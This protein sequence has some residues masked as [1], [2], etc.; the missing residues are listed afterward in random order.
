MLKNPLNNAQPTGYFYG[1]YPGRKIF[2]DNNQLVIL[3]PP[4]GEKLWKRLNIPKWETYK[5]HADELKSLN[6]N[7]YPR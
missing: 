4:E 3:D 7:Y 2:G 5:I 6:G 1:Y